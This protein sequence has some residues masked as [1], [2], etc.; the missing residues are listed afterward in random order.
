MYIEL[1]GVLG[2]KKGSCKSTEQKKE[3][4]KEVIRMLKQQYSLRNIAKL[5]GYS[6]STIQR[7][8]KEFV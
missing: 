3:E 1:G 5:T 6:L 2:R 7:I 4:Y 8:K